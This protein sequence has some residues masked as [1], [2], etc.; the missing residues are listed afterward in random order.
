MNIS[1]FYFL[2]SFLFQYQWLDNL[3][4]FVAEPLINIMFTVTALYIFIHYRIFDFKNVRATLQNDWKRIFYI[5]FAT[6]FAWCISKILKVIIH[7]N[8]PIDAIQNARALFSETGYAFPSAH[9]MTISALTFAVFY[10]NKRLGYFFMVLSILVGVSRVV[11]GVHFPIDII[12][13]YV[14]GFLV[15]YFLKSR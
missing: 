6:G 14:F 1:I 10:V 5:P 4:W 3:I 15:A 8:R 12:G 11:A 2:N 7:T 13:G 9:A